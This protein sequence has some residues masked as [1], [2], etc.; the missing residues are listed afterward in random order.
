MQATAVAWRGIR[1]LL[2]TLCIA[3]S[4]ALAPAAVAVKH[5]PGAMFAE[6]DHRA[7]HAEHGHSHDIAGA[8]HHDSGDHDHVGAALLL[9]T[10]PAFHPPPERTRRPE[11]HAADGM[12][13]DGPRRPPRL[14][15]I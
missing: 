4:L 3:L 8:D 15:L 11:P 6:A 10:P 9:V 14:T 5:G 7:Y 2:A 12:I 13:R 1:A